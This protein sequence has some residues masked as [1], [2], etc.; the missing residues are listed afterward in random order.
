MMLC[1][2]KLRSDSLFITIFDT[3]LFLKIL[4]CLLSR[5]SSVSLL[6]CKSSFCSYKSES[7]VKFCCLS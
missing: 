3:D 1:G 5:N 6:S 4:Y 2:R 7:I